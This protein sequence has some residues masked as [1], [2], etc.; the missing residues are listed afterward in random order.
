M[1]RGGFGSYRIKPNAELAK[2]VGSGALKPS[3][4][5]K[6]IWQYIKKHNLASS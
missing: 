1:A 2:I 4:L 5:T 6:K 3:E